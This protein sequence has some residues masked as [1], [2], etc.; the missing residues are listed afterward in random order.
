MRTGI[1]VRLSKETDATTSPDRQREAC[2]RLVESR[3]WDEVAIFEDIDLSAFSGVAR[4]GLEAA[5]SAMAAGDLDVLVFYRVDRL[6]RSTLQFHRLLQEATEAGVALVSATESLDFSTPMGR[7]MAGI[8]AIFAELEAATI[9]LRVKD[10][11]RHLAATGRWRGGRRPFGWT[12]EPRPEGGYRLALVP[13]EAEV[14]REIVGRVLDRETLVA[15][16]EDLNVRQ[17]PTVLGRAW[18]VQTLTRVLRSPGLAGIT[19]HEGAIALGPDGR[20]SDVQEAL[21]DR[22]T[23]D[24]LQA[25]LVRR[26]VPR[27][28]RHTRARLLAGLAVCANCGRP[29]YCNRSDAEH[30]ASYRCA[31]YTLPGRLDLCAAPTTASGPLL[32]R[33]VEDTFLERYGRF[34]VTRVETT[35]DP[36]A[37]QRAHLIAALEDLE[38]DRYD[39]GLFSGPSG[40]ER[41][42]SLHARLT[43]ALDALPDAVATTTTV[44][45]TGETFAEAWGVADTLGRAALLASALDRVEVA[46]AARPGRVS[47]PEFRERVRLVLHEEAA[48]ERAAEVA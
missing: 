29:L 42:A 41:F 2:R 26:H 47:F 39:R 7:A 17:V 18:R 4:P 48:A 23:F 37:D 30:A 3:G 6:A 28:R 35:T 1:Y 40:A 15:I 34:Q 12:P 19:R 25:E 45:E 33:A 38:T 43:A 8:V 21:L 31:S 46:K 27:N 11:Q 16:V 5:R 44:V 32:E 9:S 24:A 14:V 36:A 22:V 13:E 20:P 10:A